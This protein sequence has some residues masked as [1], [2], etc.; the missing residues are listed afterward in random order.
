[1]TTLTMNGT[2]QQ[3]NGTQQLSDNNS[4][5][6]F[7]GKEMSWISHRANNLLSHL[8]S[9]GENFSDQELHLP[10][11]TTHYG[12]FLVDWKADETERMAIGICFAQLYFPTAF[13]SFLNVFA[14]GGKRHSNVGGKLIESDGRFYPTIRT[15]AFIMAGNDFEKYARYTNQLSSGHRLFKE[16]ILLVTENQD[17]RSFVEMEVRLNEIY[18][19]TLLDGTEPRLDAE[20]GFPASRNTGKHT[21]NEVVLDEKTIIEM[22]EIKDFAW[23]IN[24]LQALPEKKMYKGYCVCVFTGEPGTG[25]THTAVAM[26]N[27]LKMP[28]Y[29]VNTAQLVSKYIGETEKNLDKVLNRFNNKNCILFFDEAEAIFSKRTEVK[30]SHDRYANQEQSF[31]LQKM[32]EFNGI[33]I[34][35]TNV[36]DIRQ[37]MDKAFLR[38]FYRIINIPFPNY[39]ERKLIWEKT[40]GQSFTYEDGLADRMAKDYQLVGGSIHNVVSDGVIKALKA[41]SKVITFEM[42]ELALR[43]EFNKTGRKYEVCSDEMVHQFP[44]RRFGQG[45]EQRSMIA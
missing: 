36:Q 32:T 15:L 45:F 9:P 35:A 14:K 30:D 13:D 3:K 27:E 21:M 31:L 18:Y 20:V 37:H 8:L 4:N 19:P 10:D 7:I 34:L 24:E 16:G 17:A 40:L 12:K 26:G 11:T 38:R 1:M 29:T 25:K 41:K 44:A 42:M 43:S 39:P 6:S 23:K 2:S 33:I 28:V 5:F 22:N